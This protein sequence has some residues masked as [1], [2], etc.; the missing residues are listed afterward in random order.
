MQTRVEW[1]IG[2]GW[3]NL[4]NTQ[5]R[6]RQTILTGIRPPAD[7]EAIPQGVVKIKVG[8]GIHRTPGDNSGDR[9]RFENSG[10]QAG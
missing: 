3:G 6:R 2:L 4:H 8:C 7:Y 5:Q 1:K 10:H 9:L